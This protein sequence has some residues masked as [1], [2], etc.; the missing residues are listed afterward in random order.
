LKTKLSPKACAESLKNSIYV[1]YLEVYF[2]EEKMVLHP[3]FDA[4]Y[5]SVQSRFYQCIAEKPKEIKITFLSTLFIYISIKH[6][7]HYFST[8]LAAF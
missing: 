1:I 2:W 5:E 4:Q 7:N 8:I 6:P 3:A